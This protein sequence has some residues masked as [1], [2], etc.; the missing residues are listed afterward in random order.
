VDNK[1][2][3]MKRQML[4]DCFFLLLIFNYSSASTVSSGV[5]KI[6]QYRGHGY[7]LESIV[8]NPEIFKDSG[9]KHDVY[10]PPFRDVVVYKIYQF[11]GARQT[12]LKEITYDG[13]NS[14]V[15]ANYPSSWKFN[16]VPIRYRQEPLQQWECRLQLLCFD[17][18]RKNIYFYTALDLDTKTPTFMIYLMNIESMKVKR[19]GDVSGVG[20]AFPSISGRYL[21]IEDPVQHYIE[22]LDLQVEDFANANVKKMQTRQR[23]ITKERQLGRNVEDVWLGWLPGDKIKLLRRGVAMSAGCFSGSENPNLISKDTASEEEQ[24][25]D[26][27]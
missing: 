7:I 19:I 14:S 17:Y 16:F 27:Q 12:L 13:F 21:A 22:V 6:E 11:D 3:N 1:E 9:V 2:K 23:D 25:I 20:Q 5:N 18:K 10:H 8:E 15:A 24:I 26:L 4:I